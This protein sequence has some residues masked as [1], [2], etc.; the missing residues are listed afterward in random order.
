MLFTQHA[1]T[2][3][4]VLQLRGCHSRADTR[5]LPAA[6]RTSFPPVAG[7]ASSP[8]GVHQAAKANV[9]AAFVVDQC[10]L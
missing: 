10:R 5:D 6:G 3:S 8:S 9:V 7:G 4:P 2:V 1:F